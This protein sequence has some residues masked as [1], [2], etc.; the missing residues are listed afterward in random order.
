[1]TPKTSTFSL[2][3]LVSEETLKDYPRAVLCDLT[4]M[5]PLRV[6]Y[7]RMVCFFD[8]ECPVSGT[9]IQNIIMD[10]TNSLLSAFNVTMIPQS[11]DVGSEMHLS[12]TKID[13][14]L[15]SLQRN[16]SD[17]IL[18]P[19]S[20]PVVLENVT[21]GPVSYE[22]KI[23]MIS[24]YDIEPEDTRP[25]ILGTFQTFGMDSICLILFCTVIIY[26]LITLTYVL[27]RERQTPDYTIK[28]RKVDDS[29]IPEFI[30]NFFVHQIPCFPGN[31]T[32]TKLILFCCLMTFTY[33]VT[34]FYCSMIKTDMVTVKAPHVIASYQ[35][36]LDDPQVEPFIPHILDEYRTFKY[37]PSES[38]K[39]KI[40]QRIVKQGLDTH[41]LEPS[42]GTGMAL[43]VDTSIT[44][45]KGVIIAFNDALYAG[46]YL[47][48]TRVK[49]TTLRF[50]IA[51]DPSEH[52]VVSAFVFNR[53]I[54]HDIFLRSHLILRRMFEANLRPKYQ[55]ML[56]KAVAETFAEEWLGR[57]KNL[58]EVDSYVS[59]RVLLPESVLVK[60]DIFYYKTLFVSLLGLYFLAFIVL[61]IEKCTF[62]KQDKEPLFVLSD[63]TILKKQRD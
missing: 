34:Y 2:D 31:M 11:P 55:D 44:S 48:L 15:L 58:S 57:G 13:P 50:L 6:C 9:V 5:L 47:G 16:E 25:G 29:F 39:G 46:K 59:E 4:I 20:M 62:K 12:D 19:Y 45:T 53:L 56:G 14:C 37:A 17:T 23:G 26:A 43:N 10:A 24:A 1:M 35:D 33:F 51:F 18:M 61:L 30:F 32:V 52:P 28:G 60:P 8:G 22:S 38:I 21:T 7:L 27:E 40:W 63:R 41:I 54:P 49:G 3:I 42:K 36:I